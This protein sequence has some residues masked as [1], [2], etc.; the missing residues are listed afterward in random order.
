MDITGSL[1]ELRKSSYDYSAVIA[2]EK[3]NDALFKKY[4]YLNIPNLPDHPSHYTLA[5]GDMPCGDGA[6]DIGTGG[7]GTFMC[8]NLLDNFKG[9]HLQIDPFECRPC[10]GWDSKIMKGEDILKEFG[11]NSFDFVQC[12]ETLEHVGQDVARDIAEQMTKVCRKYAFITCC[13]LSHHLGPEN[14]AKVKENKFLDYKGQ[15]DIEMLMSLGYQ[16][17]LMGGYQIISWFIK[18]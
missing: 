16:V 1:E 2:R 6:L 17:R 18:K 11:E 10:T 9:R 5:F 4:A 14:A 12:T 15:P 7:A 3:I 13:G 8:F